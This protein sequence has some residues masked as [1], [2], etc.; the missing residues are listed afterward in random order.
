MKLLFVNTTNPV[1]G[2]YQYGSNLCHVLR[3]H[4]APGW[5]CVCAEPQ[6]EADFRQ[7]IER[8]KPNVIIYN[9]VELI[10]GWMGGAPFPGLGPQCIMYHDGA[11]N[12]AAFDAILYS[13]PTQPSHDKWHMIGRPL[14]Y[15]PS[16]IPCPINPGPLR[17]GI[18]GF[19]GAFAEHVIN[20]AMIDIPGEFVLRLH[21]PAS[22]FC[23][24]AGTLAQ[25][26]VAMCLGMKRPNVT[27]ETTHHYMKWEELLTWLNGNDINCYM[28]NHLEPRNGVSSVLDAALC[29]WRPIAINQSRMFRH[30]HDCHP[31]IMLE[32]RTLNEILSSGLDP[33]E[34][35]REQFA[36]ETVSAQVYAVLATLV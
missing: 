24:P 16:V 12:F 1:C 18:H 34:A 15:V 14:H 32:H 21:L 19:L 25:Q 33:L 6:S 5:E 11:L 29:A 20:K 2:V 17:V 13:D 7:V 22:P 3:Q 9:W 30:L 23:D 27:L 28:R 36:P 26:R 10:G 4:P 35:K 31:S 8:E